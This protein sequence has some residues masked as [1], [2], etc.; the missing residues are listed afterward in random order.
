M[1][2]RLA[3]ATV[4]LVCAPLLAG[5]GLTGDN[6][7]RPT[8][9]AAFYPLQYIA[10]RI[11]GDHARVVSLAQPGI[12]PHDLQLT[13]RQTAIVS[14]AEVGF[15]E[16][17]FQP[18]VDQVMAQD[19]PRHR[20]DAAELVPLRSGPANAEEHAT[21]QTDPHFWLDPTLLARAARGFTRT[22]VRADPA[23]AASYRAHD[24]HLQAD[25]RALDRDYRRGLAHC[26]TRTIVVSH[27]AFEYLAA[28]YHLRDASIAG[29]TPDTEASPKHLEQL[30]QLI[31]REHVTTVFHEPLESPQLAES[32]A[33]DLGIGTAMLDP[34]EALTTSEAGMD[35]LSLMHR[36]LSE[37]RK[38]NHCS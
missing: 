25:L 19:S 16:S 20:V 37:L 9:V 27:D 6:G 36:N 31:R 21:G 35:Y 5:C 7:G 23:H 26:A 38:A 3:V 34:I 13:V 15:F 30:S 11:V 24:R 17:G 2:R 28:R 4:L 29:L 32:L 1:F 33:G 10:Q 8:V 22:M 14:G 12:E 18:A